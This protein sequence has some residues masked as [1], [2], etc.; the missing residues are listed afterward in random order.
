MPREDAGSRRPVQNSLL[1]NEMK[2]A[3]VSGYDVGVK[4]TKTNPQ[5]RLWGW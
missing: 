5:G 3:S 1:N 4:T 2:K